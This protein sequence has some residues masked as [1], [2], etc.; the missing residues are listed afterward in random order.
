MMRRY[1]SVPVGWDTQVRFEPGV[2]VSARQR[3]LLFSGRVGGMRFVDAVVGVGA[4]AGNI[5]TN[6]DV[7]GDLRAGLNLSHPWRRARNRGPF[8]L[9][10]TIGVRGEAV[11][12]N[13]FLDGNTINPDR[14]V[15]RVPGVV[16]V[17]GSVGVRLGAL[18]LAYAVTERSREYKT[19]PRRHTYGSLVA[20]IGGIPDVTP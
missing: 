12:R 5:L 18:V 11:A 19:G 17:R 13:I 7:G 2:I 6:A 9:V 1:T 14:R 3:W 4:S 20:G 8:E 10:G 15:E 16:D